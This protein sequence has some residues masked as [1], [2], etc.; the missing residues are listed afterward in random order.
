MNVGQTF[1]SFAEFQKELARIKAEGSHPLRVFNSQTAKDY[2]RK[3]NP[4]QPA[5]NEDK[6]QYTYYSVRCVHFGKPRHRSREIRCNQKSFAMECPVK[7]TVSYD[8]WQRKL[9]VQNC[10]TDHCHR[11][12][13][14][15]LKHYPS[16]RRLSKQ[17]EKDV[18]DVLALRA[19]N[20]L[21]LGMIEAYLHWV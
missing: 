18:C 8:K 11:T 10:V 7:I 2:N 14:D 15:I 3:R 4:S 21:T 1:S 20:K 9:K 19:N 16:E 6:F 17:Q 5:V 12:S 13:K